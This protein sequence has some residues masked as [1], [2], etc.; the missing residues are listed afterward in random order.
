LDYHVLVKVTWLKDCPN[1]S[2]QKELIAKISTLERGEESLN[3]AILD[4][5]FLEI[6]M[7]KNQNEKDWP[8]IP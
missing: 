2:T 3:K 7:K 8:W 6:L 1:F 4:P 5:N